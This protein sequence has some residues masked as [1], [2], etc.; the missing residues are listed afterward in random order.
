MFTTYYFY[1]L[2]SLKNFLNRY[3]YT[4][5]AKKCK[6][7]FDKIYPSEKIFYYLFIYFSFVQK[8]ILIAK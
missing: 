4:V 1:F 5:Y 8:F 6:T 2:T 3:T 7:A